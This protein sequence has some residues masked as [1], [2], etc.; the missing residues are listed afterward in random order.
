M[1]LNTGED[2]DIHQKKKKEEN[3]GGCP[4]SKH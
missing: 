3:D 2:Q 4:E 1:N